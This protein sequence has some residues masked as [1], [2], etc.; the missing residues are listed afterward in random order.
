MPSNLSASSSV[1]CYCNM[2]GIE[3]G[4]APFLHSLPDKGSIDLKTD[5]EAPENQTR[6]TREADY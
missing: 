6:K 2:W 3:E 1:I 4:A 5:I